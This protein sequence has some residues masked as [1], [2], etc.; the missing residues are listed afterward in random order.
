MG[1]GCNCELGTDGLFRKKSKKKEVA[2]D[3]Q[4]PST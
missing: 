2:E 1:C 3:E 4:M